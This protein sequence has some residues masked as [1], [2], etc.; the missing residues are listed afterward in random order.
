MTASVTT[1]SFDVARLG[2]NTAET[3]LMP[4]AV[5]ARGVRQALVLQTPDDPRLEAQPLY[6]SG[7]KIGGKPR[8]VVF[9]ATMGN[10]SMPG[11]PTRAR[12]SG[13]RIWVRQSTN[14]WR[15]TRTPSTSTVHWGILSAPVIDQTAAR[16]Y[17]CYWSSHDGDWHHGQHFETAAANRRLN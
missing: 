2:A 10:W 14:R 11:M 15:S 1:R 13:K 3:V 12:H 7:A 4:A 6:L 8:N 5:K 16:L 9:Q 17:T